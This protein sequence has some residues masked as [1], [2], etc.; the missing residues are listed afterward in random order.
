LKLANIVD[1]HTREALAMRV[2][3][4]CTADDLIE[5]LAGLVA[6][7]GAPERLRMDNGPEL[8]AWALRDWCRL[9]GTRTTYI[10]PGAP[11]ENPY[12]ESFNGR[13]RDELLNL[14][15]FTSL[16]AEGRRLLLVLTVSPSD[17]GWEPQT[18]T[19]QPAPSTRRW[20]S[21][22]LATCPACGPTTPPRYSS[23]HSSKLSEDTSAQPSKRPDELRWIQDKTPDVGAQLA[24]ANAGSSRCAKGP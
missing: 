12:V 7:R 20:A 18:A 2:G 4:S 13:V 16:T 1:E 19:R 6:V 15:E 5:V 17:P 3:R 14:E 22:W 24:T 10:E 21:S 9:T 23:D 11:W 8:I